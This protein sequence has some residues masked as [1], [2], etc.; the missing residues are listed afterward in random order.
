MAPYSRQ[1]SAPQALVTAP[2]ARSGHDAAGSQPGDLLRRSGPG[3]PA[4]R[5]CRRP[6]RAGG[7][8]GAAAVRP[9]R[10]AGAGWTRPP[11]SV[12]AAAGR[13]VRMAGR[14]A[15][16]EHRRHARVRAG[17]HLR[18]LVAGLRP[19][20]A[21]LNRRPAAAASRTG[22][23]GRAARRRPAP[24]RPAARRRTAAPGRRPRRSRRRRS[25]RCRRTGRRRRAGWCPRWSCHIPAARSPYRNEVSSAEPSTMAASTTWPR[26]D[27]G[28]LD[29]RG[30]HPERRAAC[31]RRR[32]RRAG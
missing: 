13:V 26:P 27:C 30:Q 1:T 8:G 14:L 7:R 25:R 20:N 3:R 18:P 29:Q 17:E 31:R 4:P 10:G 16:P 9:K 22:R 6:G 32:S 11:T 15:H 28:P 23:A 12:N 19:A 2:A 24:A 5:R 21:A